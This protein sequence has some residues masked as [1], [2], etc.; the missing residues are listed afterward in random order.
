[1]SKE[2]VFTDLTVWVGKKRKMVLTW[3][4]YLVF[5]SPLLYVPDGNVHPLPSAVCA[6]SE[7][8]SSR[9]WRSCFFGTY[10]FRTFASTQRGCCLSSCFFWRRLLL[11]YCRWAQEIT[12]R[13]SLLSFL[14]GEDVRERLVRVLY[15]DPTLSVQFLRLVGISIVSAIAS[16]LPPLK[17]PPYN[18][19]IIEAP[20]AF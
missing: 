7:R 17:I 5:P 10:T 15:L 2:P 19:T 6:F 9:L 13:N 1:M 11:I 14:L 12:D 8:I 3:F 20:T 16:C 18:L 4:F